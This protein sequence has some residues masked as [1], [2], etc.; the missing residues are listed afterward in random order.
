MKKIPHTVLTL[1][2]T[3]GAIYSAISLVLVAFVS[4][5]VTWRVSLRAKSGRI[6]TSEAEKLWDEGTAMRLELRTEVS[7]L[8]EQLNQATESVILLNRE[9]RLAR[10]E[11]IAARRE[12]DKTRE[13]LI[14]LMKQIEDLARE[15]STNNTLTLGD[16][17]ENAETR[18][19]LEIPKRIRTLVEIRHLETA[20][21]HQ[22]V[23]KIDR[24]DTS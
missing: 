18:R 22:V 1:D 15:V 4:G 13:G 8:K 2:T 16:L 10:A 7:T 19:I 11:T 20:E 12:T 17:A 24:R 14:I 6:D 3:M 21:D 9:I 5:M 23:P